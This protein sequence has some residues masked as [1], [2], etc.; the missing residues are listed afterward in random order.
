MPAKKGGFL[1]AID[2]CIGPKCSLCC[3]IFSFF[4]VI[5]LVTVGGLIKDGNSKVQG[6]TVVLPDERKGIAQSA[7]YAS[8][9]YVVFVVLCAVRYLFVCR[10]PVEIDDDEE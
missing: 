5:I 9:I 6:E 8:I 7:F 10:K 1:G 4:G 3:T 2:R